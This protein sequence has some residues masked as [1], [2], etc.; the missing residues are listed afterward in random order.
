VLLGRRTYEILAAHWPYVTY[1]PIAEHL[2]STREHVAL[3]TLE[4]VFEIRS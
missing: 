2:N 3:T 1:D 4:R